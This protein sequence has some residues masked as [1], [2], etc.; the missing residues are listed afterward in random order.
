MTPLA[1]QQHKADILEHLNDDHADE[2]L[3]I[4]R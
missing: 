1:D 3:T 4:T 2:L